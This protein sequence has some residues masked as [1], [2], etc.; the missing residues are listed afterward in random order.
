MYP[1]CHH[2]FGYPIGGQCA[3]PFALT[4]TFKGELGDG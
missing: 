2:G 1:V 3:T 4:E